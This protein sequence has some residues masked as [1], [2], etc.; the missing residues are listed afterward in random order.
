[1]RDD[2]D[3]IKLKSYLL[4]LSLLVKIE[5]NTGHTMEAPPP[6]YFALFVLKVEVISDWKEDVGRR[7]WREVDGGGWR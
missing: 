7:K 6:H 5:V 3:S 1:M 2:R 4:F